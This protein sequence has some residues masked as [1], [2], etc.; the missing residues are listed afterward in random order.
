MLGTAP[1]GAC[2]HVRSRSG[3]RTEMTAVFLGLFIVLPGSGD[4]GLMQE[5]SHRTGG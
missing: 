1:G 4:A 2:E 3:N 5:E